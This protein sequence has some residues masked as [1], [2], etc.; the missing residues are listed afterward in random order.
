MF[1]VTDED[2]F[3]SITLETC[4]AIIDGTYDSRDDLPRAEIYTNN[5]TGQRFAVLNFIVPLED[6]KDLNKACVIDVHDFINNPDDYYAS[7]PYLSEAFKARTGDR[8]RFVA[9]AALCYWQFAD[10]HLYISGLFTHPRIRGKGFGKKFLAMCL[11]AMHLRHP[12]APVVLHAD[13][14]PT[15]SKDGG[16]SKNALLN[17]YLSTNLFCTLNKFADAN[18]FHRIG[19]HRIRKQSWWAK[20]PKFA[21][22]VKQL[23]HNCLIAYPPEDPKEAGLLY[24]NILSNGPNWIINGWTAVK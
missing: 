6:G 2:N 18:G 21:R 17:F 19:S 5:D 20:K 11:R 4:K 16:L 12:G 9:N 10:S 14:H 13:P 22:K 1:S 23:G 8:P 24:N 7:S 15:I 3:H